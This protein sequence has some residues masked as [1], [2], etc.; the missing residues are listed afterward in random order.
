MPAAALRNDISVELNQGP[1]A[2]LALL[3]ERLKAAPDYLLCTVLAPNER[4][5]RLDRLF[6]TNLDQYPLGPADVVKDD[7]WFRR[8][9]VEKLPIVANSLDEIAA[10]LPDYRIFIEQ[11]YASLLNMP[12]VF[13]GETIGLINMMGDEGHFDAAALQAIRND[14]PL[15][16]LAIL[17]MGERPKVIRRL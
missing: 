13:A 2:L 15:A 9:F 16:A 5:D 17:G 6:S 3:S 12:I 10:W 7:I 8:L 14:L 4:G 11:G 1:S